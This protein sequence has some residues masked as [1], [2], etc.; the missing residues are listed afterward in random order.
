MI[1]QPNAT[2]KE[3]RN[4]TR[5]SQSDFAL[6]YNIPLRTLQNWESEHRKCADYVGEL[7]TTRVLTRTVKIDKDLETKFYSYLNNFP[8][9]T[10]KHSTDHK[11]MQESSE[12]IHQVIDARSSFYEISESDLHFL[13]PLYDGKI[14]VTVTEDPVLD[15][16]IKD[17]L[18]KKDNLMN[19]IIGIN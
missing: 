1:N 3:L 13:G 7:L 5:L 11:I 12:L 18:I 14:L 4:F 19:K 6:K 16:A 9:Y 8:E 17:F 10:G 2:I 15:A